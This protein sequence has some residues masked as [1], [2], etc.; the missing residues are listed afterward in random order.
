MGAYEIMGPTPEQRRLST[1]TQAGRVLTAEDGRLLGS[2]ATQ[3]RS[4]SRPTQ[5][6]QVLT[7]EER[8][9][10]QAAVIQARAPATFEP[11][12]TVNLPLRA[13]RPQSPSS[14]GKPGFPPTTLG[15]R[16]QG[17]GT[18]G[19]GSG[20]ATGLQSGR[21]PFLQRGGMAGS[22][23]NATWA[24]P[25]VGLAATSSTSLGE[26]LQE[27]AGDDAEDGAAVNTALVGDDLWQGAA[28]NSDFWETLE[29]DNAAREA[30]FGGDAPG[31]AAAWG[32]AASGGGVSEIS[33]TRPASDQVSF[34]K[35]K[36]PG[37]ITRQNICIG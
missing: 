14:T 23:T 4:S 2:A 29:L 15:A 3:A 13:K 19:H 22:Q 33:A 18:A 1:A 30:A 31:S 17:G 27:W 35:G 12:R 7:A 25:P 11:Q 21:T 8:Q 16:L 34:A 6:G 10:L 5:A 26:L 20:G 32:P 37:E 9:L 36:G 28:P 24:V